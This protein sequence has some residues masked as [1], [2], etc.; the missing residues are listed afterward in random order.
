MSSSILNRAVLLCYAVVSINST[1][2]YCLLRSSAVRNIVA[3]SADQ[4]PAGNPHTTG[5][6]QK[7]LLL[8]LQRR[9]VACTPNVA[10]I[11]NA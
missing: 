8:Q 4:C 1:D 9:N 5:E 11:Q 3:W 7:G 6:L 10:Y 2:A